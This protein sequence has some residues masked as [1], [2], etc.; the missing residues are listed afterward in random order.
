MPQLIVGFSKPVKKFVPYSWAIR[1]VDGA[2]Y[3]HTYIKVHSAKYDRDIVYQASRLAVNF[4]G[5]AKFAEEAIAVKEY[6]LEVSDEALKKVMQFAIDHAGDPYDLMSAMG[7][8]VSKI[9][10]L[11]GKKINNPFGDKQNAY[12]CS[13]LVGAILEDLGIDVPGEPGSMTPKDIDTHLSKHY[14]P[15]S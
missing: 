13:E 10:G 8:G 6:S 9:A 3:S 2:E 4:M 11:F 1:L 7:L 5:T 14:T 15:L 12:F